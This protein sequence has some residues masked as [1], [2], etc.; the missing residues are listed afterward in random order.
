M[1]NRKFLRFSSYTKKRN[2]EYFKR[3]LVLYGKK[4]PNRIGILPLEGF[5]SELSGAPKEALWGAVELK[6]TGL[7]LPVSEDR[8]WHILPSQR[9]F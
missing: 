7:T 3:P 6:R 9:R 4:V 5:D 1:Y 8:L 2:M